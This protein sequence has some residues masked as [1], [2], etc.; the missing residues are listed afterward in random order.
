MFRSV[1]EESL[2]LHNQVLGLTFT[3]K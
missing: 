1:Q 3:H 2:L